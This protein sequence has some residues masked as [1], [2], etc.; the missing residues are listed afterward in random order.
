MMYALFVLFEVLYQYDYYLC[1]LS[2]ACELR[3]NGSE[4][5]TK[6]WSTTR[7]VFRA[8]VRRAGASYAA[9]LPRKNSH[10]GTLTPTGLNAFTYIFVIFIVFFFACTEQAVL[11]GNDEYG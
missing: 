2:K 5:G 7:A 8:R 4:Y 10:Y 9:N 3:I 6:R 1:V 11:P